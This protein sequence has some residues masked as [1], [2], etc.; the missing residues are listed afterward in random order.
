MH[1]TTHW[2]LMPSFTFDALCWLNVL[3]GDPFYVR[4]YPQDYEVY[5]ERLTPAA[6]KAL[7]GLKTKIKDQGLLI[8]A[9]LCLHFSATMTTTDQTLTDLLNTVEDSS[10]MYRALKASEYYDEKGWHCYESIR[11]ELK[12]LLLFLQESGFTEYWQSAILP[13]VEQ[14]IAV[15]LDELAPFNVIVEDEALLGF[16]LPSDEITVYVLNYVQP[17]GIR[18]LGTRFLTDVT[19]D[20]SIQVR[21]AVHEMFHPPYDP[22]SAQVQACLSELEADAFLKEAFVNHNPDYGYNSF[23]GCIEEG[24][25]RALDQLVNEKFAI[26]KDARERW[27]TED[28]GMHVFAACLY[29]AMQAE[30][31]NQRGEVFEQFFTRMIRSTLKPGGL[32]HLYTNFMQNL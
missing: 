12:T 8:S 22:H 7:S 19:Y 20:S 28:E 18:I 25:V 15:L 6:L 9:L 30:Q 26:A 13:S 24:C 29:A 10:T 4:Y 31:Y 17:H 16:A 23:E 1:S 3:T 27:R 14:R 11:P 2:N 32:Q 5:K 21:T